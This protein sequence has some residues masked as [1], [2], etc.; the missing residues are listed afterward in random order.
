MR[1]PRFA[2]G[3]VWR[4][5]RAGR[6]AAEAAQLVL[7]L[8]EGGRGRPGVEAAPET[9]RAGER[10]FD[11][12]ADARAGD[13]VVRG[14]PPAPH[15]LPPADL[16]LVARHSSLVAR[17]WDDFPLALLDGER[18]R[19][20]TAAAGRR[21]VRIGMTSAEACRAC[22][23]LE[24]L[25]WDERV[26]AR[27]V[28]RATAAFLVAS[29]QVTPA[30]GAPGVWWVGVGGVDGTGV[31]G[32]RN[33]VRTL[34]RVA[35]LWHPRARVAVADSG[36]AARA[37][38]WADHDGSSAYVVPRGGCAAYLATAP[39]ALL[40]M[41]D[42]LRR[43]LHAAGLRT[44]GALAALPPTEVARRWG[45][46]G[47]R[48]WRLA[49]GE[50]ERRPV[51]PRAEAAHAV[52][53]ELAV[54]A[55][56]LEPVLLLVRAALER[57]VARLAADGRAAAVVAV[58]LTLDDGRGALPAG[59][60]AHTV[61]RELRLPR[62]LA[63][64]APL[65]ERCRALLERWPRPAPVSGVAVAVVATAPLSVP[66]ALEATLRASLVAHR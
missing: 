40:P 57:L 27:E 3:A 2:I 61:T 64:V 66:A 47:T 46:D 41:P 65:L 16:P 45:D 50:D 13:P 43:A 11:D 48:A 54:P 35:S 25:A 14:G 30:A 31:G 29:P 49:H 39:L 37:A 51:L 20:V 52:N 5:V 58:T 36:V 62:P 8:E 19:A 17:S 22:A 21:G 63:E 53:V 56:T 1:I 24:V 42:G 59:G 38:T 28:V 23:E 26:V 15:H 12:A 10:E 18:L 60:V 7:D 33:L 32:E 34:R 44:A 55:T 9:E 4:Q 6:V